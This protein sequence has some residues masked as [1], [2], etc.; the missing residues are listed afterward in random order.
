[1]TKSVR[2]GIMLM[3]IV[4][5]IMFMRGSIFING[6]SFVQQK[7]FLMKKDLDECQSGSKQVGVKNIGKSLEYIKKR[8][9]KGNCYNMS[10]EE[11]KDRKNKFTPSIIIWQLDLRD[12]NGVFQ[13]EYFLTQKGVRRFLEVHKKEIEEQNVEW[14][15]GGEQLW[16]W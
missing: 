10:M 7:Q 11:F 9:E 1:M 5:T 6:D 3:D 16:L 4:Y 13:T 8:I 2:N 15:Y 12:E 14:S